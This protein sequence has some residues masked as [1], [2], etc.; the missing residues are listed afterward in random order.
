MDRMQDDFQRDSFSLTLQVTQFDDNKAVRRV[1]R[2]PGT[3]PV[4]LLVADS[5]WSCATSL[6]RSGEWSG[7]LSGEPAG[8]IF[9]FEAR[10]QLISGYLA[11]GNV[12]VELAMGDWSTTNY[13]LL[14]AAAY[15]GNRY[16]AVRKRYP[17]FL[18]E[19]D[20]IGADMP[21]TI[22]PVPRLSLTEGPSVIHLRS[23]DLSTPACGVFSPRRKRGLLLLFEPIT[24]FGYTGIR[25][26]EN[27][28]R[29]AASI[30]IEAP[31]VREQRYVM[32]DAD[33]PS[34]DRG[35]SFS[36]GDQI[37]LKLRLILF[38]C[39]GIPDL[40]RVFFSH[41]KDLAGNTPLQHELPWSAAYRIIEDKYNQTQYNKRYAYYRLTPVTDT[42]VYGDWQ[43]GWCGGG[44]NS[45]ALAYNGDS[46]SRTRAART[47]DSLFS[48]LQHKNGYIVSNQF[49][50]QAFGDDFDHK[51]KQNILL[52]RKNGDV[53]LFAARM[54][55]LVRSRGENVPEQW[56]DGLGRLADAFV[57]L[58]QRCGQFGQFID[59][60]TETILQ[61]GTA[62]G[63]SIPGGLIMAW[64][65]LRQPVY[66]ETAEAAARAYYEQHVC[67]GLLNG[68]PGEILQNPD[69]ES[70]SNLLESYVTL[71]ELTG[72]RQW[73]NMA[74][75]TAHQCASWVVSY[76]F[77]FPVQSAF[78]QLGLHTLGSVYANV[79]N[80]HAAPG[81]CTLSGAAWLRLARAA[82]DRRY[83]ELIRETAHNIT[84]YL[85]REDRPITS[86]DEGR[87]L[88]PG[89]MCERVNMSDW[90]D[91]ARI[92]GVFF[93]SCWC[94]ISCLLTYAEIP[95][96]WFITDT[97]EATVLDHVTAA[98]TEAGLDWQ[99]AIS[100]PT[101]FDAT[102]K[103]LAE[104]RADFASP[105][106]PCVT[107]RCPV[108]FVE[109][110]ATRRISI[111]K[112]T[113][114]V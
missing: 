94:E 66:R 49:N 113:G 48:H 35:S 93:G 55:E 27:S 60:E 92:G 104:S 105:W 40:Y 63:S 21:V 26:E 56:L 32:A 52:V 1:K 84:Q 12:A 81:F 14:P 57:R 34:D 44:L 25:I 103:I 28:D 51:E 64:R 95:G 100:N 112:A 47:M 39:A 50:G 2:A 72:D 82:G 106:D 80:K 73:L 45:L 59:T 6:T 22:T 107:D 98:V 74:E 78:G 96:I 3:K 41:R 102:V 90:E 53:L 24:A 76:D 33:H 5:V 91:Q 110:G 69:S 13:V 68:G 15:N 10:F 46:L 79:Q 11:G 36:A 4:E 88:P 62:S 89:W 38:D 86:W 111:R 71:F 43:A 70:T 9:D 99:L 42:S 114:Q 31:A 16:R 77:V 30:T 75:Q 67:R 23:G 18:H 8:E 83:L 97:G 101:R 17:P 85:S 108:V 109:A 54:I 20:G 7:D 61:G 58:W 19:A 87:P 65:I 29:S 37:S